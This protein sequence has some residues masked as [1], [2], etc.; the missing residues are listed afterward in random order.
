MMPMRQILL[1]GITLA[2]AAGSTGILST[3]AFAQVA[4]SVASNSKPAN[5]KLGHWVSADGMVGLVIDRTAAKPRIRWD[6]SKDI[7]ELTPQED[8]DT[9]GQLL[10][11]HFVSPDG[12]K[13]LYLSASGNW[14]YHRGKDDLPM[15]RDADAPP[16]PVP[17]ISGE[18]PKA[19]KVLLSWE[20]LAADLKAVAVRTKWPNYTP[21]DSG[22]LA[23]VAQ[24][25]QATDAS[26]L[27]HFVSDKNHG[28]RW[29]PV[30]ERIG[31]TEYSGLTG[32]YPA[33]R[34]WD[35]KKGGLEKHGGILAG[36]STYGSR[37]NHIQLT[38]PEGYPPLLADNTPGII[39]EV[40]STSVVF[41]T[42]DGG[43]YLVDL[44]DREMET[45]PVF[46]KG[47][48]PA[49]QW[50]SPLQHTLLGPEHVDYL[51][52]AG[53]IP[54]TTFTNLETLDEAWDT[55]TQKAWNGAK[56]DMDALEQSGLDVSARD[57]KRRAIL[58]KWSAKVDRE[59]APCVAK[60]EATLLAIIDTRNKERLAIYEKAKAHLSGSAK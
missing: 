17:T 32:Y 29:A 27:V 1:S 23:K 58:E 4:K 22:N 15:Q 19:Q 12:A 36:D 18:P 50:P 24:A 42:L 5:W 3:S 8:R 59:C 28:H 21:E 37:G 60:L 39:W 48:P 25:L 47:L 20:S 53:I 35:P 34:P 44:G 40:N 43:R 45:K 56:P 38:Q 7:I 10:G 30:S 41:V 52:R 31:T 51:S 33:N 13:V 16:L 54:K 6:G 55:C 49:D 14:V 57:A 26:M 9:K 11:Y 2:M 46:A